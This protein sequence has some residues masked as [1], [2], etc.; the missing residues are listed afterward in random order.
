MERDDFFVYLISEANSRLFSTNKNS[1]FTNIIKPC[2]V[3]DGQYQVALENIIFDDKYVAVK[4]DDSKFS[5]KLKITEFS[6][7][8]KKTYVKIHEYTP[9]S[10]FIAKTE[11]DVIACLNYELLQ[12]VR[13]QEITSPNGTS[14]LV[15]VSEGRVRIKPITSY[16]YRNEQSA[17][18]SVAWNFSNA[19]KKMLGFIP[20][21]S[22]NGILHETEGEG[23]HAMVFKEEKRFSKKK[24][25][26]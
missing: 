18:Y 13:E 25:R 6:S 8:W 14:E 17:G 22:E 9:S 2:I 26:R 19:W 5:I 1:G 12:M 16:K 21:S 11:F 24:R 15:S 4:K 23:W 7:D 20:N 3:L 10:D